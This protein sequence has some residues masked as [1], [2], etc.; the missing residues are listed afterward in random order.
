MRNT[1]RHTVIATFFL[2]M[3]A[4]SAVYA[5]CN[6]QQA[7]LCRSTYVKCVRATGGDPDGICEAQYNQCLLSAGC[8]IP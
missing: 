2:A 4:S 5:A 6:Q 3:F 1:F 7:T 8:P